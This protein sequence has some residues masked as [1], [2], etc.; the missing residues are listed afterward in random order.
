MFLESFL[1]S[2]AVILTVLLFWIYLFLLALVFVLQWPT[3]HWETLIR[4]LSQFSLSFRQTQRRC[5]FPCFKDGFRDHLRNVLWENIF[6]LG[7]SAGGGEFCMVFMWN[8]YIYIPHRKYKVKPHSS[9][10]FPAACAA[11][12]VHRN[13][14]FSFVPTEW[15]I[16]I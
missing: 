1:W 5:P 13:H 8:W 2:L 9:P 10:W 14:F 16:W 4:L 12:M 7:I 15:I 11:A 3:L 6:K